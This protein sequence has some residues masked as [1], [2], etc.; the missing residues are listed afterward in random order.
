SRTLVIHPGSRWLR[1]GL[2]SSLAPVA[3]PNVI[4]RKLRGTVPG[5][6]STKG[7]E[8]A[9]DDGQ[10]PAPTAAAR[11]TAAGANGGGAPVDGLSAKIQSI[12][13]D[14]R[15]RMRA[16]KLRGQGN[17][18]SQAATYN[19][20][21]VPQRM[22]EDFEGDIEWTTA[23]DEVH[24][25]RIPDAEAAGY[26]L[27][28][29]FQHGK[30]NTAPYDSPQEL[31]GDVEAIYTGVLRDELD[32]AVEEFKDYG[33]ILLIPD[34]YDEVYVREMTDL[35]VRTMGFKQIC[36]IQESVGATFGA[37]YS[38]ACVIDIGSL[39]STITCVEEGLVL[40]ET[41]MVLDFGGDDIT[42]FLMT[43]LQR[44]SFP[45]K[46]IDLA[47]WHDWIVVEELKERLVV[48]S[49]GDIGLNLYDFYVRH[50]GKLT[51]KYSM[52]VYDDC[53]L[54][55]YALF[56][57]RVIDFDAKRTAINELW[58]KDVD[59]NVEIGAADVTNAMRASVR[60]LLVPPTPVAA[61]G[62]SGAGTPAVEEPQ[63]QVA[64]VVGGGALPPIPP[65][66]GA[67]APAPASSFAGSPAPETAG[68]T[69][70]PL[71]PPAPAAAAAAAASPA[72]PPPPPPAAAVDVA[73]ESS[74][75]PL[76][77]AIVESLLAAGPAEERLK[78]VAANLLIVGGT[79]G[80]HNVGFAVQSRVAPAL[81][82]RAPVIKECA[83]VPCPKEIEPENL[84]WKGVGA[85]GRLEGAQEMWIRREEWE[86]LGMRAVRERA[87]YWA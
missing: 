2:A 61:P 5:R 58:S 34:L 27:R 50:P 69:P 6:A 31:L 84:A 11:R 35:L 23:E 46:D 12:R 41:R 47:K 77:V 78:K 76:D 67:P 74:K 9:T 25:V 66:A 63:Q 17:G 59:D 65:A 86:A 70:K 64:A 4:A 83:Y 40:P 62:G 68:G 42:R 14:L 45:Y 16:Y 20:T 44:L 29:P 48:L 85:L 13:G 51:Q 56:A 60:H 7:K 79:G 75:L 8:R 32:I 82:V 71:A 10:A 72:P 3:V 52:R 53:I 87:F 21:V 57:P 24:A 1:I 73:R 19:A 81:A 15:A 18:N 38:S 33:V 80:I 37:G 22:E 39:T 26:D 30:F 49:E 54:A 28:W 43:L 36:L 55:P